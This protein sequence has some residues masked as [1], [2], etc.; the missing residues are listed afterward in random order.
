M[1]EVW[2][3]G[4]IGADLFDESVLAS[5]V[6]E[7]LAKARGERVLLRIN[8]PGGDVF[9]GIAIRSLLAEHAGGVDVQVDGIA[10]SAASYIATI[11]QHVVMAPDAFLMIHD[12][13]GATIGNAD[14]HRAAG[15]VLDK[16]SQQITAA[17]AAKSGK[18]R[19]EIRKAMKAETWYTA[20]GAK[21]FGLA[22][23]IIGDSEP[24]SIA[25]L[26][27]QLDDLRLSVVG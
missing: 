2:L 19:A 11:G 15:E 22:D 12:C 20:E 27:R 5:D 13:W 24:R 16:I 14:D 23:S 10:A 4:V 3:Y 25:A 21:E 26:Q 6:R 17:Y 8:S 9:E 7:A 18:S 1:R